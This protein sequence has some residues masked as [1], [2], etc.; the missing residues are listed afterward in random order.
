ME[1]EFKAEFNKI[2]EKFAITNKRIDDLT[3]LTIKG[4]QQH[5]AEIS[6]LRGDIKSLRSDVETVPDKIDRLYSG[7]FND[8]RERMSATERRVGALEAAK[9]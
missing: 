8:L 4:L 6:E 3:Q 7:V 2:H 9:T 1:K 5:Q